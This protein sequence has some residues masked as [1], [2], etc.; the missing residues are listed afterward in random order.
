MAKTELPDVIDTHLNAMILAFA[1]KNVELE[2]LKALVS[3]QAQDAGKNDSILEELARAIEA[4]T[5]RSN[6]LEKQLGIVYASEPER[7]D[8]LQAMT[9]R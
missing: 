9:E 8:E 2:T 1:S 3:H 6:D 4:A 7:K 5:T